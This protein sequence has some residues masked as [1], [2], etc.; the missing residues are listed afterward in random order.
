MIY[1]SFLWH[2]H[3]PFY[4]DLSTGEYLLPWVRLHAIKDYMG[5]GLILKEFPEMRQSFNFVPCLLVQLEEYA[6]GKARDKFQKLTELEPGELLE[7]DVH[8]LLDNFFSANWER[9][10]EPYPRYRELLRKR[11]F[12]R[13]TVD[14]A[15]RDFNQRDLTD[16]QVWANLTWFH[17]L[18]VHED[19]DLQALFRKGHNFTK[20][21]KQMVLDKQVEVID[22]IIRLY[23]GLEASGQ[24][25]T[26][27]SP[28]YHAILP[29]LC[30]PGTARQALPHL[31]L[32]GRRLE[33]QED[34]VTQVQK[35]VKTHE[36]FFGRRPRGF[37]PS[38][39]A[40]SPHI[41]PILSGAGLQWIASDEDILARTLH[42]LGRGEATF[43][44]DP[45]GRVNQPQVLYK[46]YRLE[47]Q[48]AS[49]QMI[50]RDHRLSDLIG[51]EYQRHSPRAAAEDFVKRI[52]A[53]RDSATAQPLL[54]S[55]ILDGE[56]AWEFYHNSGLDFLRELY[57]GILRLKGVRTT[58]VSDYLERHPPTDT[59]HNLYA[60]SWINHNLA[61]WV[62]HSEKNR[63]W[64]CVAET[65]DFLKGSE[66]GKNHLE[67]AWESIYISEGSDW[68]WW[69]GDDHSSAYDEVF[70]RLFRGHLK[71]VYKFSDRESPRSLDRPIARLGKKV[72]FTAPKGFLRVR[73]DGR[74]SSFIEWL[75]A[76]H[77]TVSRDTPVMHRASG[78]IIREVYFGFDE[79]NFFLRLDFEEGAI[80]RFSGRNRLVVM[81]LPPVEVCL[82]VTGPLPLVKGL[83]VLNK[84][85]TT[86]RMVAEAVA[87]SEVLELRC[88]FR[89]LNLSPGENAEFLVEIEREGQVMERLPDHFP[90]AFTTPTRDFERILWQV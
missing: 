15:A 16:L 41:I 55:V 88:P 18:V 81:F 24:I 36:A 44:R 22:K 59:L 78:G 85:E 13:K 87:A 27:T 43:S 73:L 66:P 46:P 35:A 79:E 40:V 2:F 3:Q 11:A 90:F 84:G 23:R 28:F 10:I 4:K 37:W 54:V 9:M 47:Y 80:E 60:G 7:K 31:P 51:F 1:L 12:G 64:E 89:E 72:P 32:P 69:Y 68:Y 52:D 75:A 6:Q 34:A 17:P 14:R 30:E 29:L 62:G 26:T 20:E 76:G 21:E 70:D 48:G 65:R 33:A 77:Y 25:E 42:M 50:F 71:N 19:K 83:E 53:L 63:A 38:E 39:G 67:K 82:Q 45:Q 49:L 74:V 57:G 5:M 56:N 86:P 61:T 58:R 8:Y